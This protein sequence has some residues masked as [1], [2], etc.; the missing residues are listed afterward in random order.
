MKKNAKDNIF[1]YIFVEI[2]GK[3]ADS[4]GISEMESLKI[5]MPFHCSEGA[6]DV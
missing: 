2:S 1:F 5:S 3:D 6:A 4:I